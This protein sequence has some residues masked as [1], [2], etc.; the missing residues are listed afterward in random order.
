MLTLDPPPSDMPNSS[1]EAASP[2][3]MLADGTWAALTGLSIEQLQQLQWDQEQK[4]ANAIR[5]LPKGSDDRA[6]VIGQAYDTVCA[7]LAAQ[8]PGEPLVMGLDQRYG[9][10]VVE[11][12]NQQINR[13]IGRPSFFEIGFGCGMMLREVGEHGFPSS[14]I[15]VSRTMHDEA[16]SMLGEKFADRL[17]LGDLRSVT[18]DALPSRPSLVYWND[19]FEHI[20]P[21]EIS[22]YLAKI[23]ELLMPGG[24]LVTITPN[25][26]LRPSDVTGDFCPARTEAN[27]L[28]LKEYR[29][30]EVTALLK[31]AGFKRVATPL[32]VTR[33]RVY[34][35]GSGLRFAKQLFEPLIDKLPIK[36]AH[37]LVRGLGLSYTI[38]T[39]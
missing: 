16:L 23:Y 28:H 13:G 34:H 20:C 2:E 39:K 24:Q 9:K 30:A 38:A 14:G 26:L 37:L 36:P 32:V 33:G 11:L 31:Q 27:G 4:F 21:D 12:L 29:L 15:E 22:D 8:Q 7:I 10:L 1:E 5:Q 19:V 17:L 6:M 25:W 35:F 18:K 3:V